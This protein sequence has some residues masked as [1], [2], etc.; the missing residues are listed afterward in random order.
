MDGFFLALYLL[1]NLLS[2][3]PTLLWSHVLLS[4]I[5]EHCCCSYV[6][7]VNQLTVHYTVGCR[8]RK[9]AFFNMLVLVVWPVK[10][11]FLP[12]NFNGYN[13]RS[14]SKTLALVPAWIPR[15]ALRSSGNILL[16]PPRCFYGDTAISHSIFFF[17]SA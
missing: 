8:F 7:T 12:F 14:L 17:Q 9:R 4:L 1:R 2:W 16:E 15:S 5:R 6:P 13:Q 11:T 3:Y 10:V